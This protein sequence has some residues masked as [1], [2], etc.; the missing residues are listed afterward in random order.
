VVHHQPLVLL[1]GAHNVAGAHSLRAS[2]AEELPD[3]PR[4]LVVGLLREKDPVEMLDALGASEAIR[5]ICCRPPSARARDPHD[6]AA[7]ALE[8]GLAPDQ[9]E[10]V[11]AVG[12]AVEHALE[13]TAPDEQVIVAGSLYVVG[14]ARS[15]IRGLGR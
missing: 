3:A 11:E 12:D 15:A 13:V 6:L 7:A 2:L 4:T 10:V 1:D 9:V 5:I 8:L 14:A